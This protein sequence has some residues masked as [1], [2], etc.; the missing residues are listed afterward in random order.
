MF[1]RPYLWCGRTFGLNPLRLWHV[2]A[3]MF[4]GLNK[5]CQHLLASN[6]LESVNLGLPGTS[7]PTTGNVGR[8]GR[9]M[10]PEG[11]GVK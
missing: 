9:V 6:V 5:I 3:I 8:Q 4:F 10:M 11:A 2:H 7:V 1:A